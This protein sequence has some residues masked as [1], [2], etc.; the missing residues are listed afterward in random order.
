MMTRLGGGGA[1]GFKM[2]DSILFWNAGDR[3]IP[4]GDCGD[5]WDLMYLM[6]AAGG[7]AAVLAKRGNGWHIP[8][9]QVVECECQ[10]FE[11][12]ISLLDE[13]S[14]RTVGFVVGLKCHCGF[15]R[16]QKVRL[17]FRDSREIVTLSVFARG[18]CRIFGY[19][20]SG[21]E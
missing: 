15:T 17:V 10:G 14:D 5:W 6:V 7:N 21:F 3:H 12:T 20:A 18:C 9:L 4:E 19:V 2:V 16:P 11:I 8:G 13:S 1:A